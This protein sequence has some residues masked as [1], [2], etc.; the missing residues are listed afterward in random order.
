M[1]RQY[2]QHGVIAAGVLSLGFLFWYLFF[3]AENRQLSVDELRDM[4]I[5][6]TSPDQRALGAAGLGERGDKDSMPLLFTAME[7]ESALVRA[8]AAVAVKKLLGTDFF[9][10]AEDPPE[11]RQVAL[12]K[13]KSLWEAWKEKT[14]Y[15]E[16]GSNTVDGA[17]Q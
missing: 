3:P 1:K 6:G 8:R 14:G 13:Y 10:N 4:L 17:Q 2:L 7:D 9:F 15:V 12:Q 5:N 16:G 11:D